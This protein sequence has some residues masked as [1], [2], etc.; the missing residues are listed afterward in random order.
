[1]DLNQPLY[2]G[3]YYHIYNRGNNHENLF[4]KSENYRYFLQKYNTYTGDYLKTFAYCLLPNHFHFLVQVK[5][6]NEFP[7]E[8]TKKDTLPELIVCEQFIRLFLGYAQAINKQE[9]RI[10]SL[11]QKHFK[12]KEIRDQ[13]HFTR[14][15]Y[16]IHANPQRHKLMNDFILYPHSSYQSILSDKPTKLERNGVLNWF[17]GK[18]AFKNFHL[19]IQK[20]E[21]Y[22]WMIEE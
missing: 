4:Y 8:R 14:L 19:E 21:E 22:S 10:G 20:D 12:R 1:M 11:F 15:I 6:Y 18:E 7:N 16:Y 17:G 5:P 2:E 3:E 9:N 13:S